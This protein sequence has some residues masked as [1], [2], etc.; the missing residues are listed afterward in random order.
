MVFVRGG[1]KAQ[2]NE[3]F[4]KVTPLI[5]AIEGQNNKSIKGGLTFKKKLIPT[6]GAGLERLGFS[7]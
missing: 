7:C 3:S 5:W 2:D 1:Q 4:F 6:E